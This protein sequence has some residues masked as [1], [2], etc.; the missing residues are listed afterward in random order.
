MPRFPL[1][2]N[3]LGLQKFF[4]PVDNGLKIDLCNLFKIYDQRGTKIKKVFEFFFLK[5]CEDY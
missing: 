1:F 5:I 4:F 3:E 2:V